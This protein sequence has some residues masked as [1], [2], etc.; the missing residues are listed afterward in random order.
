MPANPA[1]SCGACSQCCKVMGIE[2]LAKPVGVWCQ[3]RR[4]G[5]GCDIHGRHPASCQAFACQWLIEPAAPARFRPDRTKVVL[6]AE[7]DPPRLV[8]YCDPA[9]PL[10]WRREPIYGLLKARAR[11]SPLTVVARAGA[12]LWLIAPDEDVD[13]GEVDAASAF[14]VE[15]GHDGRL[16]V[17]A[18]PPTAGPE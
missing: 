10:A 11:A 9:N 12:R 8:A 16:R 15:R 2:E 17:T 7:G 4:A 1:K 3:H 14:Q 13:L 5:V 6:A 18:L